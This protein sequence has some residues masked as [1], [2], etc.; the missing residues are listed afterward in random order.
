[1][2]HH[3]VRRADTELI[4]DFAD[5]R[6]VTAIGDQISD[7]FENLALATG[8]LR[9][10]HGNALLD[11]N[12]IGSV[13]RNLRRWMESGAVRRRNIASSTNLYIRAYIV[14]SGRTGILK[15]SLSHRRSLTRHPIFGN[16][17]PPRAAP[18][19]TLPRSAAIQYGSETRKPPPTGGEIVKMG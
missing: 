10:V 5:R 16:R 3:A 15:K 4:S 6:A 18:V 11:V 9:Q 17:W 8:Q 2:T 7:K 19:R 13:E 12:Q 1:M 14:N